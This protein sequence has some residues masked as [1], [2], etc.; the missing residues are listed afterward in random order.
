MENN[1]LPQSG[2][3]SAEPG[4]D[5]TRR[6]LTGSALGASAIFTL[7]SRPVLAMDCLS[8]SGF[9]SG[10][11]S[12]HGAPVVCNGNNP[13]VWGR[14]NQSSYPGAGNTKF[15][16]EFAHADGSGIGINW[17]NSKLQDVMN[18]TGT[19]NTTPK[20]NPISMEFAAALLN[21]RAG[22]YQGGI[23]EVTL[24]GMWNEYAT[25]GQYQVTAGP[26]PGSCW[27]A[28]QIVAYLVYLRS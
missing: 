24:K 1:K 5:P 15:K 27:N 3:V 18:D 25:T 10:N 19:G 12:H 17:G 22:K 6:R 23:T 11:L 16:T 2:A 21:I 4:P 28:T 20:P 14:L 7:A 26:C 8:P 9:A 13:A